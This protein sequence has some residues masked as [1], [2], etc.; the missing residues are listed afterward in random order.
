[1]RLHFINKLDGVICGRAE[2]TTHTQGG[3][4]MERIQHFGCREAMC[5]INGIHSSM[6]QG[7]TRDEHEHGAEAPLL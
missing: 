6:K 2:K 5:T 3:G 7:P 4:K 1:M